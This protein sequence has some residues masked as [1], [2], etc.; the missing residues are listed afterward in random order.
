M[1]KPQ[2]LRWRYDIANKKQIR[3]EGE[4][5]EEG[6]ESLPGVNYTVHICNNF[7]SSKQYRIENCSAYIF[8]TSSVNVVVRLNRC[9]SG[10]HVGSTQHVVVCGVI[11]PP[12]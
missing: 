6:A 8:F 5:E 1:I 2:L 7:G 12:I 3:E 4:D 11:A 9:Q 10:Y